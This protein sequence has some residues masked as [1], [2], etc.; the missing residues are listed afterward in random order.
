MSM[1]TDCVVLMGGLAVG[2]VVSDEQLSELTAVYKND[3][4]YFVLG[5]YDREPIQRLNLVVDRLNR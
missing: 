3:R 2:V 4:S 1:E 5:N